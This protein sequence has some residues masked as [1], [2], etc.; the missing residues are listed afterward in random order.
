MNQCSIIP[1][2]K[3]RGRTLTVTVAARPALGSFPLPAVSFRDVD[4][5]FAFAPPQLFLALSQLSVAKVL[6]HTM[7]P[8]CDA[9]MVGEL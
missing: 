4:F 1:E 7:L 3:Q 9:C 6:A 8:Q 5:D 2:T